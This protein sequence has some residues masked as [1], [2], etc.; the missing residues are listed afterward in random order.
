MATKVKRERGEK[1]KGKVE[2]WETRM[3]EGWDLY[4]LGP[5]LFLHTRP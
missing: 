4:R 3:V 1:P 5:L 2:R